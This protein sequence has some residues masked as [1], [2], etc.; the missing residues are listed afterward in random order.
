MYCKDRTM[1]Y[2][3]MV[4][5]DEFGDDDWIYVTEDSLDGPCVKV[6]NT[7]E[8]AEDAAEIWRLPGKERN[9]KVV[10]YASKD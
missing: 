8:E 6:Y 5:I 9:V 7:S 4:Q 3:L 1:K 10:T 2:A